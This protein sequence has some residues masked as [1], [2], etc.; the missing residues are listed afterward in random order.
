VDTLD[1]QLVFED[2]SD[3]VGSVFA[4]RDEG[5]PELALTLKQADPL[6]PAFGLKG[7]RPPFALIFLAADP[8]V[9]PQRLYRLEHERL[10]AVT[11]FL[12]PVG[13]DDEGVS[14]QATFN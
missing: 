8:R 6:N 1:R 13:K 3:K 7:V 9:L 5:V 10:G 11:I 2:F 12:V 4:L 14:Y